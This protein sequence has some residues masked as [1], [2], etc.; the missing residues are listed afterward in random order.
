MGLALASS[1]TFAIMAQITGVLG[2]GSAVPWPA[3]VL[4]LAGDRARRCRDTDD[5]RASELS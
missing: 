2:G 5:F 3:L 4:C 1:L